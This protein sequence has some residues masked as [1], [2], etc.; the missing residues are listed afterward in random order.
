[1]M[2]GATVFQLG[3]LLPD[4]EV[5]LTNML[6]QIDALQQEALGDIRTVSDEGGNTSGFKT[7]WDTLM[8]QSSQLAAELTTL[9]DDHIADWKG[10]ANAVVDG[11]MSLL[12]RLGTTKQHG[13]TFAGRQ[14]LGWGLGV[15]A[16]VAAL[17]YFVWRNK[18]R[19][20]GRVRSR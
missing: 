13:F 5:P 16:A 17:S 11:L 4:Q 20:R 14:G 2:H 3:S 8:A 1:M 12:G 6:A 10:R 15:S 7:E 18:K 9:D 19:G